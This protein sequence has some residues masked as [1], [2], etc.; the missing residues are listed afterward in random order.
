MSNE[1]LWEHPEVMSRQMTAHAKKRFGQHFLRDSGVLDRIVRFIRPEPAD[2]IVEVGAGEGA[3]SARLAPA[4]SDLL[5]IEIDFDCIEVLRAV[6][7]PF[8]SAVVEPGNFLTLNLSTLI[9]PRLNPQKKLRFVG[10]LPFNISTAVIGKVLDSGLPVQD[11]IFM[12]QLEVAQRITAAPGSRTYGCLSVYCRHRADVK[13]G[14]RISPSCF[15]P[16]PKVTS[17]MVTIR[18]KARVF[19]SGVEHTFQ[20]LVKAAFAHRRKTTANSFKKSARF[21]G[22][23][24]ELLM[25][26]GI[27]GALR[28]EQ[29]T[30]EEYERMAQCAVGSGL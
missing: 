2:L 13:M 27:D 16:R 4:V 9:T 23:I 28:P 11:M 19:D 22:I 26:T 15:V 5:A 30:V 29:L 6:L 20:E 12:V 17:A 3:L 1:E 21:G 7:G 10:N 14:F 8:P 18:P 25:Q 24:D